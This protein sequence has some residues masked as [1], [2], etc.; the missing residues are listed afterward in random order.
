[1]NRYTVLLVLHIAFHCSA[2]TDLSLFT[3]KWKVGKEKEVYRHTILKVSGHDKYGYTNIAYHSQKD[4]FD[5]IQSKGEKQMWPAD[6]IENDKAELETYNIQGRIELYIGRITIGGANTEWFTIIIKKDGQ[7]VFRETLESDVPEVPSGDGIWWN[8]ASSLLALTPG[9]K[10][11]A[12]F[13]VFVIDGLDSSEPRREF[14]VL[15]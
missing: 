7:E 9:V 4:M 13:D 1:M 12:P 5:E 11:E 15:R 10:L 6:K 14:R 2:Q 3:N 8:N